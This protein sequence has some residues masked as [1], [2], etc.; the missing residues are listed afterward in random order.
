MRR[1]KDRSIFVSE[2]NN[3]K[4][5]KAILPFY[6]KLGASNELVVWSSKKNV[7]SFEKREWTGNDEGTIRKTVVVHM[8]ADT[9]IF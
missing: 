7:F 9:S 4:Q 6:S 3:D 5:L 2:I 1:D 8:E